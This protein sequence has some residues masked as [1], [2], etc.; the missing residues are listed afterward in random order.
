MNQPEGVVGLLAVVH[1]KPGVPDDVDAVDLNFVDD[2]LVVIVKAHQVCTALAIL[3]VLPPSVSMLL[4]TAMTLQLIFLGELLEKSRIESMMSGKYKPLED[5]KIV[6]CNSFVNN[7]G[8]S[9]YFR[10]NTIH[11]KQKM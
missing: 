5:I 10:C 1:I 4:L 9:R 11:A 6:L 2:G 8:E 3:I 7:F